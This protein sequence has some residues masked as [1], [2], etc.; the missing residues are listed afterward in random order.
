MSFFDNILDFFSEPNPNWEEDFYKKNVMSLQIFFNQTYLSESD[1]D[2]KG[3][4]QPIKKGKTV[5]KRYKKYNF[6]DTDKKLIIDDTFISFFMCIEG[7]Y[8]TDQAT[9]KDEANTQ[10]LLK[11][12]ADNVGLLWYFKQKKN[13]PTVFRLLPALQSPY[14]SKSLAYPKRLY[15]ADEDRE[16]LLVDALR[17]VIDKTHIEDPNEAIPPLRIPLP[18][19]LRAITLKLYHRDF[20]ERYKKPK[21]DSD[22]TPRWKKPLHYFDNFEEI[23]A[24]D[25]PEETEAEKELKETIEHCKENAI[26]NENISTEEKL[27]YNRM[28]EGARYAQISEETGIPEQTLRKRMER[29][30]VKLN[31]NIK[32]CIKKIS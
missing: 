30:R 16:T 17:I 29:L 12:L 2:E 3:K 32:D 9:I 18:Y 23:Y 14:F 1:L 19:L 10:R 31:K 8:H 6:D 22:N 11:E 20:K 27:L 7:K 26:N 21:D 24:N 13:P 15:S 5:P 25:F 28:L 4:P